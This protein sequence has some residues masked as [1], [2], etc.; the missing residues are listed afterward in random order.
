M[1]LAPTNVSLAQILAT[2]AIIQWEADVRDHITRFEMTVVPIP[3][4]VTESLSP[5]SHLSSS[6]PHRIVTDVD[7][8]HRSHHLKELTPDTEYE[9]YLMAYNT[10]GRSNISDVITF[11]TRSGGSTN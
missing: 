6:H 11:K 8:M 9:V 3:Q 5:N 7:G 2:A 10:E 1:P 4:S